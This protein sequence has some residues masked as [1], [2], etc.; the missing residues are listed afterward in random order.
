MGT[1]STELAAFAERFAH[2]P[3]VYADAN[4]PAGVVAVMRSRRGWVVLFVLEHEELRRAPD[5]E[6]FRRASEMRRT[7]VSL[8][9]DY[10]DDR[11]YP[12]PGSAGV[13]VVSAPDE[14]QLTRLLSRLDRGLFR[15]RET[16][17][18]TKGRPPGAVLPLEG[19]KL[20]AGVDWTLERNERTSR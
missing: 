17:S 20:A 18:A 14:R 15:Q 10:L 3:R 11:R 9:H 19:R 4:I 6:H 5:R 7:L 16:P 2:Q 8:D 13:L 12:P 1:L